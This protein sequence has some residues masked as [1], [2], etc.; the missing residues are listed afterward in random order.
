MYQA[1]PL[2]CKDGADTDEWD[3]TKDG[4]YFLGIA[5]NN[6]G[7]WVLGGDMESDFSE[8]FPILGSSEI[9]PYVWYHAALT[10]DES[11][12]VLRLYLNGNLEASI[13]T[14]SAPASAT[15]IQA[16]AGAA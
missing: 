6:S 7:V 10:F 11:D 1:I 9:K 13:Q 8:N 4:N 12:T 16:T 14:F 5:R 15:G 3:P 2:I